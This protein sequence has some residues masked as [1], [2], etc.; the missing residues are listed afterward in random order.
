MVEDSVLLNEIL[1]SKNLEQE[2][3]TKILNENVF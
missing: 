3:W 2:T 1:L